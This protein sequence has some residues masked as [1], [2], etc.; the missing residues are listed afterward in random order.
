MEPEK[1]L[2]HTITTLFLLHIQLNLIFEACTELTSQG[3]DFKTKLIKINRAEYPLNQIIIPAL[4]NHY[5]IIT[6]SFLDEWNDELNPTKIP[7]FKERILKLKNK[8]K[9]IFKRINKW[10]GIKNF[11]NSILAHNLR[12]KGKSVFEGEEPIRYNTPNK[13]NEVLFLHTL[14]NL[15]V[16]Y[17]IADFQDIETQ[18]SRKAEEIFTLHSEKIDIETELKAISNEIDLIEKA[19]D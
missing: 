10:T 7:E 6:C 15:I 16:R 19:M 3:N 14:I 18:P 13:P 8:T 5:L 12:N 2:N 11:R 9:P 4:L 1:K 17:L